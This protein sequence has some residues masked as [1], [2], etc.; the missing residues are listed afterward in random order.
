MNSRP[1]GGRGSETSHSIAM[2]NQSI[3]QGLSELIKMSHSVKGQEDKYAW[4]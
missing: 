2:I 3:N 1:F 4:T